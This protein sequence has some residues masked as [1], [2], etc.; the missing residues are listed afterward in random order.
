MGIAMR[1]ARLA[2]TAVLGGMTAAALAAQ[3][4]AAADKF[5]GKFAKWEAHQ[6]G[7]GADA[8]CFIATLPA[9]TEGKVTK[10]GE[11][12]LMI[13]H[14]AKRKAWGQ[15]Q[16]KAGFALKKGSTVELAIGDKRFKLTADGTTGF[17][18]GTKEN[19]EIV[20]ALKNGKTATATEIP[21]AGP[22]I[23]DAYSL[24]GFGKA[25]AAI[26]KACRK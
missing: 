6:T 2:L 22:K 11:A 14:F 25:L 18:E 19:A 15:V 23:V 9:K 17:G 16:V 7:A 5:L 20:A 1:V 24:D 21:A 4:A 26:D 10:R 13:A 3:P 8:V 12:T